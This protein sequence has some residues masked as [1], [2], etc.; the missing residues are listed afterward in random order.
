MTTLLKPYGSAKRGLNIIS[1]TGPWIATD[2][3]QRD[4]VIVYAIE[5]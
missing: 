5:K 4:R 2:Q 1:A 3:T